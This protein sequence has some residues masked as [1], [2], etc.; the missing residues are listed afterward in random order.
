MKTNNNN[1]NRCSGTRSRVRA[2]A[3]QASSMFFGSFDI[4]SVLVI[5]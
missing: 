2:R 4:D 1:N 3:L 5:M